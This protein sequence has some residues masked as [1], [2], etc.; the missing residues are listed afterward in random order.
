[1]ERL[2]NEVERRASKS[3]QM[4]VKIQGLLISS[5]KEEVRQSL[6]AFCKEAEEVENLS[7][8]YWK[9]AGEQFMLE[10]GVLVGG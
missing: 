1:M 7:D 10:N 5:T 6:E 2:Y 9:L 8:K 4:H 3:R